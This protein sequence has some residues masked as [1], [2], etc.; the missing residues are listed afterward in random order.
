MELGNAIFGHS[1]GQVPV[2]RSC[3][4]EEHLQRLFETYSTEDE[5]TRSYGPEFESN[6]F[7]VH[8]YYWGDCSCGYAEKE[9]AWSE[10]NTHRAECYQT[11]FDGRVEAF[12]KSIGYSD[13]FPVWRKETEQA[14]PGMVIVSWIPRD[15]ESTQ[16]YRALSEQVREYEDAA[17]RELCQAMGLSY[18]NGCAV[19]CTCDFQTRWVGFSTGN[20]HQE[21]CPIVLPNFWY[22]PTD[23]R[24][25]WYKYPL[26][27]AYANRSV[28]H[29]E[30]ALMIDACI[31]SLLGS[32][33]LP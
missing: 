28:S 7:E 9:T 1:R 8:P 27:D 2:K 24:L 29:R 32:F 19:H 16:R 21:R 3:G 14:E 11:V 6:V 12:K 23:Y 5:W 4:L 13:D 20:S 18:P 26:R 15:D 10:T 17:R 22:K 33:E 31:A 30:F 25:M